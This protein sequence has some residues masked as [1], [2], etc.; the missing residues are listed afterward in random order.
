MGSR[1]CSGSWYL[2]R[3]HHQQGHDEKGALREEGEEEEGQQGTVQKHTRN[4]TCPTNLN[5][6]KDKRTHNPRARQKSV[7]IYILV[8]LY[9]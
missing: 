6:I 2:E 9:L 8:T 5:E 1:H 3:G 7:H 4:Q